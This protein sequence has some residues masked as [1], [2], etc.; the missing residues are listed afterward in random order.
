MSTPAPR[1]EPGEMK[2]L[3]KSVYLTQEKVAERMGYSAPWQLKRWERGRDVI[4]TVRADQFL[5]IIEQEQERLGAADAAFQR[6]KEA[7]HQR[8]AS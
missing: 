7:I 8:L 6:R 2:R 5:A 1:F 3:R 4:G